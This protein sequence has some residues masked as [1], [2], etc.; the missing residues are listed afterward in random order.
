MQRTLSS[1]SGEPVGLSVTVWFPMTTIPRS[2][3]PA[4]RPRAPAPTVKAAKP[5]RPAS[6]APTV[7]AA[8]PSW[9]ASAAPDI[10]GPKAPA[11]AAT[12]AP[13]GQA[14]AAADHKLARSDKLTAAE[15]AGWFAERVMSSAGHLEALARFSREST[16]IRPVLRLLFAGASTVTKNQLLKG[17][18]IA[19]FGFGALASIATGVEQYSAST[20]RTSAGRKVDAVLAGAVDFLFGVAMPVTAL[21]DGAL[22][23]ALPL[24]APDIKKKSGGF[25]SGNLATAV[26]GAVALTEGVFTGDYRGIR[27]FKQQAASGEYGVLFQGLANAEKKLS[28]GLAAT[29][30]NLQVDFELWRSMRAA[31]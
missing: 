13:L 26:R 1:T 30:P 22:N 2:G 15:T 24:I 12:P 8:K 20:A 7:K 17:T 3:R 16:V 11:P 5:S 18:G 10:K 29:L 6:P 14:P 19:R 9:P 23:F 31:R 25:I 4:H 21:V 28:D 27:E